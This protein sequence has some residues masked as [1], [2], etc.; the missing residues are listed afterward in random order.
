MPEQH[1]EPGQL[2][3]TGILDGGFNFEPADDRAELALQLMAL[4]MCQILDEQEAQNYVEMG[5]WSPKLRKRFI[6]TIQRD[7]RPTPAELRNKAEARAT[8]A[9]RRLA[10]IADHAAELMK[11]P[12]EEYE[13]VRAIKELAT[14]KE[15]HHDK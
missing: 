6:M 13:T 15:E 11:H 14:L 1:A 12:C 2:N 10:Q 9:E 4:G 7:H 8:E 3:L 5:V